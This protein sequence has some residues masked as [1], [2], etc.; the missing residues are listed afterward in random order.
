MRID[1]HQHFWDIDG[2]A[3]DWLAAEETAAIRRTF[4][5]DDLRPLLARYDINHSIL[6]E[7]LSSVEETRHFCGIAEETD[8]VGGVVGWVDLKDPA[9]GDTVASLRSVPAGRWLVGIR[10]QVQS[11]YDDWL[12]QPDV[13]RGLGILGDA[14]LVYDLLGTSRHLPAAIEA[15]RACPE[16]RFVLNHIGNPP[17]V[18][19]GLQP[20]ADRVWALGELPNVW[21]KLSG[22]I[23]N[24]DHRDWTPG[25]LR[26]YVEH[27]IEVFGEDRVM[28]GSDWPV[29]LLAGDYDRV[30][31]ALERCIGGLSE[32]A[33]R[34]VYGETALDVYRLPV[35]QE[36]RQ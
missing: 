31:D 34:K 17:I 12:A 15:V 22:M 7:V 9:V 29:C 14:D 11:E 26:P 13:I 27:V 25:Q 24:A 23:T 10:H 33:R 2:P 8:I 16:T 32:G 1:A 3:G 6:V 5:P 20:W 21:C 36:S 19:A 30:V 4:G 35:S 18:D 28:F